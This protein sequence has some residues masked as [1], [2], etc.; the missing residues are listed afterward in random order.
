MK[1]FFFDL[2]SDTVTRDEEGIVREN[3][4][5]ARAHAIKCAQMMAADDA[6]KGRSDLTQLLKVRD[7]S[8]RALC[9]V[10][11]SEALKVD[12]VADA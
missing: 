7:E 3:V 6:S 5:A 9:A 11:F 8:G 1:R 4:D 2:Y 10:R 12:D